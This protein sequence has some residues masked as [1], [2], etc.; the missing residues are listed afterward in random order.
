V[1]ECCG[2]GGY[3][4][5][6]SGLNTFIRLRASTLSS[7]FRVIQLRMDHCVER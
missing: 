5:L 7:D 4:F 1:D 2:D 3:R 6:I